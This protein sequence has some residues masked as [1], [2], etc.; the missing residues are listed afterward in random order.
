MHEASGS[1]WETPPL[2]P[3][4]SI[5]E[6][7]VT[8]EPELQ[9]PPEPAASSLPNIPSVPVT[10]VGGEKPEHGG[11][12]GEHDEEKPLSP[13]NQKVI[14]ALS[15]VYIIL[16]PVLLLLVILPSPKKIPLSL[17]LATMLLVGYLFGR[18]MDWITGLPPLLGYMAFGFIY[19]TE[20]EQG[21]SL[22]AARPYL[23]NIAFIIV[24]V[25]ASLHISPVSACVMLLARALLA[26]CAA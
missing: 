23:I 4:S 6:A 2:P 15:F 19:K 11:S 16:A 5:T 25:R 1:P 24:L 3:I 13:T 18:A 8:P 10:V 9:P 17:A 26:S 20:Q 12:H 21:Y 7:S 14:I 22:K